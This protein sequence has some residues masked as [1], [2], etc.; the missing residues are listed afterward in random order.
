MHT[1]R[2]GKED[3]RYE[4]HGQDSVGR[5]QK[6]T[7]DSDVAERAATLNCYGVGCGARQ[8]PNRRLLGSFTEHWVRKKKSG[9]PKERRLDDISRTAGIK[10]YQ[11]IQY[12]SQLKNSKAN[13]KI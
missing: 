4:N 2:Y 3:V 8:E 1:T 7:Q 9:R 6:R 12:R 5:N 10:W 13:G 11:V